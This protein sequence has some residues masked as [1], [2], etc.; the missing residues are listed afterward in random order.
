MVIG[1]D[2]SGKS[3]LCKYVNPSR[4]NNSHVCVILIQKREWQKKQSQPSAMISID[5]STNRGKLQ[6]MIC[7]VIKYTG[8]YD[9]S[10]MKMSK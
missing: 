7:P 8:I 6:F 3:T 10:F 5:V 1:L 2:G 4:V 9:R